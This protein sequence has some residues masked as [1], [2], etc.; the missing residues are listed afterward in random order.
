M[1]RARRKYST[2]RRPFDRSQ[3]AVLTLSLFAG[4]LD[5]TAV[6]I[7]C[8]SVPTSE[9]TRGLM[10]H[11]AG[12]CC[13]AQDNGV[14]AIESLVEKKGSFEFVE[15]SSPHLP[16]SLFELLTLSRSWPPSYVILE[17][18]VRSPSF[19]PSLPI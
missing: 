11:L 5:R 7:R 8:P 4:N 19:P 14:R 15:P 13:S 6:S 2:P 16:S 17:T 9:G 3:V 10:L 12:M 1:A 18:S